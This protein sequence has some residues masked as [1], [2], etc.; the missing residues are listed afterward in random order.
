MRTSISAIIAVVLLLLGF[1]TGYYYGTAVVPAAPPKT[2]TVTVTPQKITYVIGIAFPFSGPLANYGKD[3]RDSVI[4]AL[5]EINALLAKS[6]STIAFETASADTETTALGAAKAVRTLYETK[7]VQIIVGPLTT[8]EVLGAKEFSDANRIVLLCPASTGLAAAIPGDFIFRIV[9]PPD[10]YQGL[11]LAQAASMEGHRNVVVAY[12]D[13]TFGVGIW[14]IFSKRFAEMGGR[15][16]PLKF[17]PDQPDYS[18]EVSRLA[19]LVSDAQKTGSTAVLFVAWEGEALK[20]LPHA[21]VSPVL[22]NVRWY[23]IE[24]L[25]SYKLLPPE[26][27]KETGDFLAGVK[28]TVTSFYTPGNPLTPSFPIA[29]KQK[30]GREPLPYSDGAYDAAYIA[31]WSILVAGKYDGKAIAETLPAVANRFIGVTVQTYL[32]RNGDQ[33]IAYFGIYRV[34]P[35]YKFELIGTFDGSTGKITWLPT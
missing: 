6:G 5:E 16:I 27:S 31:A 10:N 13:D 20:W 22:K 26:T 4:L 17:A 1:V 8:S 3:F 19:S 14:E 9:D 21:Q 30:Y 25:K 28:F 24:N 29:F 11:A 32:D 33:A 35:A 7:R 15:A 2:V 23:G 18:G 12:R 34:S